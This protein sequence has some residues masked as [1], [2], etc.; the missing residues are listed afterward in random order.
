MKNNCI[1]FSEINYSLLSP[2]DTA[3]DSNCTSSLQ[4]STCDNEL[5]DVCLLPEISIPVT[6]KSL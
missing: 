1:F 4:E 3:H 5:E 6:P 2:P